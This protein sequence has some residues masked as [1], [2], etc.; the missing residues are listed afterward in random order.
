MNLWVK[1]IIDNTRELLGIS[2][3]S[4]WQRAEYEGSW[5]REPQ[6]IETTEDVETTQLPSAIQGQLDILTDL[7][8]RKNA[9]YGNS[10]FDAPPLAPG[11]DTASAILVRMGDKIMRLQR[12]ATHDARVKDESFNDTVRDL[13][14]YCILYLAAVAE[15]DDKGN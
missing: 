12:L 2:S 9:D 4:F 7:L 10:A 14:G 3:P 8:T 5:T 15:K 11:L 1:E 6:D 13:A